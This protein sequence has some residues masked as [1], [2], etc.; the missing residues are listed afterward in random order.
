M[1]D[2]EGR[3]PVSQ[4]Q[5]AAARACCDA[6]MRWRTLVDSANHHRQ[7]VQGS[8]AQLWGSL[9]HA[10]EERLKAHEHA[11]MPALA[12]R[13]RPLLAG[14]AAARLIRCVCI[15]SDGQGG[16]DCSATDTLRVR[17]Q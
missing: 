5:A 14:A 3:D 1:A 6:G 16:E 9:A 8:A 7:A 12:V 2:S 13:H 4:L 15:V 10:V 17:S 11:P